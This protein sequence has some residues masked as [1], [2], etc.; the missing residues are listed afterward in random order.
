MNT[1]LPGPGPVM[2][3]NASCEHL[4]ESFGAG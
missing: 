4:A 3:P 2:S 1:T